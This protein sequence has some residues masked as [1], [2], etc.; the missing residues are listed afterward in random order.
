MLNNRLHEGLA[1]FVVF[2]LLQC[3]LAPTAEE[4]WKPLSKLTV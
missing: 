3:L 4:K 2:V 1:T